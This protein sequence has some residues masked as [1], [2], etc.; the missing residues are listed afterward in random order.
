M[1]TKI[2]DKRELCE[3]V[4]QFKIEAP[5]L[6]RKSKAGQFVILR[7]DEM[8]ERVPMSIGGL[9]KKNGILT[10]VIQEVGKTSGAM[11]RMKIG[12]SFA[13]LVG[14]LGL[15]SHIEKFGNCVCIGGGV[16]I[17]PIFPIAQAL[18][19]AGNDVT[20]IIGARSKNLL[21]FEEELKSASHRL[22]I[23]TDD[24]SY[25]THGFVTTILQK[26][27]D[28]GEKIDMVICV[29]PVPMMKAV[30]ETTRQPRIKT[31][32]SLNPIM[33]DGTGMCGAC[34]VTVGGKTKFACVDGPDF[35]GHEVDFEE[36]TKRQKMYL[37]QEK[38]AY[39]KFL[40]EE[41]NLSKQIKELNK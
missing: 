37:K 14:P 23:S 16:G 31:F 33:V 35:D 10:I 30:V 28:D 1:L 22:L 36:M 15:P 19:D 34:R 24:G 40:H 32:V 9:D 41:C 26:L 21:I 2:I 39:D 4:F 27:I 25:G 18:K 38:I 29:G 17:P 12:D 3:K 11:N 8:G 6:V 7:I 13:D 5:H 20:S